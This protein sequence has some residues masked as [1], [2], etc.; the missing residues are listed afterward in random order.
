M[1]GRAAVTSSLGLDATVDGFER[2]IDRQGS[3]V[4]ILINPRA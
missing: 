4:K 1:D 3:D 2:L